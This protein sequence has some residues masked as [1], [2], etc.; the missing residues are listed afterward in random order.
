MATDLF[1][2]SVS[3]STHAFA[4]SSIPGPSMTLEDNAA[5]ALPS[6][7]IPGITRPTTV[8]SQDNYPASTFTV[9]SPT[10]SRRAIMESPFTEIRSVQIP[11]SPSSPHATS[12]PPTMSRSH[13]QRTDIMTNETLDTSATAL[14]NRPFSV[15]DAANQELSRQSLDMTSAAS[16]ISRNDEMSLTTYLPSAY[17]SS[18]AST[19]SEIVVDS[20]LSL[21][22]SSLDTENSQ[23]N[24]ELIISVTPTA[25]ESVSHVE[26]Q[27]AKT[28]EMG[29]TGLGSL[30][31]DSVNLST[32]A[33]SRPDERS[34][35]FELPSSMAVSSMRAE[36]SAQRITEQPI[37]MSAPRINASQPG[38]RKMS[39][40][41]PSRG[42]DETASG[43]VSQEGTASGSSR[44][45]FSRELSST[46]TLGG[47]NTGE[48]T[49]STRDESVAATRT[50]TS[51]IADTVSDGSAHQSLDGTSVA[52]RISPTSEMGSTTGLSSAYYRSPASSA[53]GTLG[54]STLSQGQPSRSSAPPTSDDEP[55]IS[56]T[57]IVR[58]E[59]PSLVD[60]QLTTTSKLENNRVVAPIGNENEPTSMASKLS[61]T[62][63]FEEKSL[64]SVST[65]AGSW[66]PGISV[67]LV[68]MGTSPDNISELFESANRSL[69][70]EGGAENGQTPKGT[71][72]SG[73]S[74]SASVGEESSVATLSHSSTTFENFVVTTV[75]H[76]NEENSEAI[77]LQLATVSRPSRLDRG[78]RLTGGHPTGNTTHIQNDHPIVPTQPTQP[79]QS[80][81]Y[82]DF[83][84]TV[85]L[86]PSSHNSIANLSPPS[87]LS[88]HLHAL[89]KPIPTRS[90]STSVTKLTTTYNKLTIATMVQSV[91]SG[92]LPAAL[93]WE[94]SHP[95]D[96]QSVT[97]TQVQSHESL[98]NAGTRTARP[99][100]GDSDAV[101]Q[102][103]QSLSVNKSSVFIS[104]GVVSGALC[105][106]LIVFG[107]ARRWCKNRR[108]IMIAHAETQK[109][110][111]R[112]PN[113]SYFSLYSED[114]S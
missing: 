68:T 34:D 87:S 64:S 97:S 29:S 28:S 4:S 54:G 30:T 52:S 47:W 94:H 48:I 2:G 25:Q 43:S 111:P 65:A 114:G 18:S 70:R 20:T 59:I 80:A 63:D 39:S 102:A 96:L 79:S 26:S 22:Q 58:S 51:S 8:H 75:K 74:I 83:R 17:Y 37:T 50:R 69:S 32:L 66:T 41:T 27:Y 7:R 33:A 85:L 1:S 88:M 12:T 38:T 46:T 77:S 113:R 19:A 108:T 15:T 93:S 107:W 62:S 76:L 67:Q 16:R 6:P 100:G 60:S 82:E 103:S 105:V 13:S 55:I 91:D 36:S 71:A 104:V 11:I 101:Y 14:S 3:I 9:D 44:S 89:T 31:V 49:F 53:H 45:G 73:A 42:V 99:T 95:R 90:D 21:G 23:L 78:G 10:T 106:F 57:D 86:S 24:S 5:F 81:E 84:V 61:E 98:S 110:T 40:G 72:T 35:D 56:T 92:G 109:L 112:D